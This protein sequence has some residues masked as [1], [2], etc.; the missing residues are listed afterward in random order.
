M[1]KNVMYAEG[2]DIY[3]HGIVVPDGE[4][5]PAGLAI[6]ATTRLP[7]YAEYSLTLV[8]RNCSSLNERATLALQVPGPHAVADFYEES[9]VRF[10]LRESLYHLNNVVNLYV[11][12]CRLFEELHGYRDGPQSGNTGDSRVLF[13]VDAYLG[14]ARRV[15][16]AISKVLW[17][18]YT[19][20]G[21]TGRWSSMRKAV[22][23]IETG[24]TKVPA[25][26]A[27]PL[28]S[29]WN[30]YGVSLADYRNYVAHTGALSSS[31]VC[32]MSRF[33]GGRWGASV[34]LLENPED[35]KRVP[36]SPDV[37]VD[38]L[39]Y[40]HDVAA[41]LAGLCEDLTA[42]PEVADYLAHPPGYGGRPKTSRS[43][44]G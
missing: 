20:R 3:E 40:C 1:L 4:Q 16:E 14:A 25:Q 22:A 36:V 23:A 29:S 33:D 39:A 2:T 37:A 9:D 42:L 24:S 18:H 17:K 35:K 11:R 30:T 32:W 43:E 12:V 38:A 41:H 28:I 8:D 6:L 7:I 34:A 15:Y 10:F 26:F 5:P 13:E 21:E 44:V 31:S 27:T 19:A